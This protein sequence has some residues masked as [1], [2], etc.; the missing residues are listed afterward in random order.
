MTQ[1]LSI[2]SWKPQAF[3]HFHTEVIKKGIS[4]PHDMLWDYETEFDIQSGHVPYQITKE[5]FIIDH[6]CQANVEHESD[7]SVTSTE[8]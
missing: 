3:N 4:L 6:S 8:Q 7:W 5:I 2:Q 1:T